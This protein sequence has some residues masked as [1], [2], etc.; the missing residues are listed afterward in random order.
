VKPADEAV[1]WEAATALDRMQDCALHLLVH[2][3][4]T[5][6]EHSKVMKRIGK[7]A[8]ENLPDGAT[9]ELRRGP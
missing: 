9:I 4:L 3:F 8:T 2:G 1:A 7:W 5:D 6:A